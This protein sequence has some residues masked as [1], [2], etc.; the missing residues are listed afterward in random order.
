MTYERSFSC[1]FLV[2]VS[3]TENLGRLSWALGVLKIRDCLFALQQTN[4]VKRL[5][6]G[7]GRFWNVCTR[8]RFNLAMPLRQCFQ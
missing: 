5:A 3:W 1:E 6:M 7:E 4:S 8:A 2:R